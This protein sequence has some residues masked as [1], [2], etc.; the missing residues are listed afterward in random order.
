M[1]SLSDVFRY[2]AEKEFRDYSPLYRELA[3][4]IIGDE[5]L[6]DLCRDHLPGQPEPNLILAAVQYL[7]LAGEEHELR[8]YYGS[9][10]SE[11]RPPEGAFPHF[12]DF[13]LQNEG[14]IRKL[15]GSRLVQTNDVGRSACLMP[16]FATVSQR[17]ADA[18][19]ALVDFGCSAGLNLLFDR[20]HVDYGKTS[21]GDTASAVQLKTELRGDGLPPVAEGRPRV[22]YRIGLDLNPIDVTDE[23]QLLWLRA[24]IWPEHIARQQALIAAAA[25]MKR[26][27]QTLLSG[28]GLALLPMVL[29]NVPDGLPI[30]VYTS[31]VMYQFSDSMRARFLQILSEVAA[32]RPLY[33]VSMDGNTLLSQIKLIT[34]QHGEMHE[35]KLLDCAAHGQWLQWLAH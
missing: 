13:C 2:F 1:H 11:P 17:E 24:L 22:A 28:D 10:V 25:L 9:C 7:L 4:G 31:F 12:R 27:P 3:S 21:W 8:N 20:F 33:L 32:Q 23:D 29:A 19:L 18:H 5:A 35:E 16:A 15:I 26:E 30:L 14:A 34:W 6:L